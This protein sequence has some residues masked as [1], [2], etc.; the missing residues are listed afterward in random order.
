[1]IV[2]RTFQF[3]E[4]QR[5][6]RERAKR[7]AWLSIALLTSAAALLGLTLGQSEAMKTAWISDVLTIL[8]P[9]SLL[10]AS[11][12][13]L[14]APSTRF[15]FGYF[16]SISIAFL[17]TASMLSIFGLWLLFDAASK[18]LKQERPPIGTMVLFGHQFWAGWAMI[19]ALAYS[20]C[21]GMLVGQLK[22]PVAE[23]LHDKELEAE[24]QM[25]RDEWM[26]EG[27]AI[28]GILLVG[29]GHWWGDAA[30][31]GIISLNIVRD[32]WHNV[33]QVVG[34]LMDESPT[35][36]G[37]KELEEL[38]TKIKEAAERM[39]WVDHAAVRLREQGHVL[40]GDVFVVPRDGADVVAHV[41]RASD[42][43]RKVDWRLYSLTV[44]P[45]ARLEAGQPPRT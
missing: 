29:F 34:D 13:E 1:M 23:K 27:A 16:R 28:V 14:R 24:A 10:V 41:E 21:V 33:R 38:P 7:L 15:P 26:S 2:G 8:P 45:V 44:V 19:G 40:A 42:E 31:A 22:K 39:D 11:R 12:F 4:E 20:V 25:N 32:G 43:L 35:K 17:V 30:A 36:M 3:P 18:L 9:A 5:R 6:Q 37:S